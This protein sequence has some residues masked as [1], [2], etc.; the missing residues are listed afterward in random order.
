M[1]WLMRE[2]LDPH[3]GLPVC[4]PPEDDLLEELTTPNATLTSDGRHRVESKDDIKKR[5]KRQRSTNCAD[6]VLQALFGPI[7]QDEY[8]RLNNTEVVYMDRQPGQGW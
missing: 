7:L 3:S 2:A 1:W 8:E 4:L 5:L 6:A